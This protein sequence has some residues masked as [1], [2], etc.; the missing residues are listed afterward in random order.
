MTLGMGAHLNAPENVT[1]LSELMATYRGGT[2]LIQ[3]VIR[4]H[5]CQELLKMVKTYASTEYEGWSWDKQ[6]VCF[7]Q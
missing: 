3:E 2:A 1:Q 4:K 7:P 6:G 5:F